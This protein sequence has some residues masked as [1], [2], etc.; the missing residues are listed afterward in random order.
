MSS[1]H[2]ELYYHFVWATQGRQPLLTPECQPI[3][4]EQIARN[5]KGYAVHAVNGM[6]DHI[7]VVLR[8]RPTESVYSA[9][10]L[11]KG[12]SSR[13]LNQIL[14]EGDFRWQ[15][16]YGAYSVSSNDLDRVIGYVNNQKKHHTQ[17]PLER[18][19]E[20]C[21]SDRARD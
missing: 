7:H 14:P 17:D 21:R 10:K 18:K 5:S 13:F 19:L 16:G 2:T 11:L 4:Y 3:L 8:L 20:I 6:E 1:Y 9:V 15:E 12:S